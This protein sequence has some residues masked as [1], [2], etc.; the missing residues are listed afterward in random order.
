MG[1]AQLQ[2]D[3]LPARH[4]PTST[5]LYVKSKNGL[6]LRDR[7]VQRLV[8]KMFVQMPWL[9]QS[10]APTCR[11]WAQLEVLADRAFF[12]LR[13]HGILNPQNEPR[14]L[15]NDFR[16]IRQTQMTIAAQLGMSPASRMA[17]KATG[18]R[19]AFDLASAMAGHAEAEEPEDVEETGAER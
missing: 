6:R 3:K 2:D 15:L 4:R 7:R 13:E 18:T 16:M 1:K 12:E 19:A 14:R 9:E 8:R 11:A 10:D 5:G 17:I